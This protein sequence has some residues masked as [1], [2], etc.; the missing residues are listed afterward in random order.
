MT[1]LPDALDGVPLA[2]ASL[3]VATADGDLHLH[4]TEAGPADGTPVLLLHGFPEWWYGWRRVIPA[5]ART[6]YRVI[7]P[8]QRGYAGSDR[9]RHAAAYALPNLVADMVAVI[10]QLGSGRVHL[11][12]HDWG[13]AVAWALATA[14][15]D[16]VRTLT[17]VN[18]PHPRVLRRALGRDLEQTRR[19][20][21][22]GLFQLPW[23]PE[24]LLSHGAAERALR[25]TSA[26]GTFSDDELALYRQHAW[27]TPKHLHGPLGW[28]RAARFGGFPP[29]RVN[30]PT[31]LVWGT[32]DHALGTSLCAPSLERCDDARLVPI[33]GCSHWVPAERP[34]ALLSTLQ[35]HFGDHGGVDPFVYK[36]VPRA[37]WEAAG[38]VWSGSADDLRDGFVH[39]SAADQ[40][41]GT[42]DKHFAGQDDLLCLTVDPSQLPPCGLRWEV[43]RGGRRFP[44]LYGGLPRAAVREVRPLP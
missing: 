24:R 42:R 38:V 27:A 22:M 5:L 4:V 35:Q 26:P 6:G 34:D 9:P 44:H 2:H 31:V 1:S 39:L 41:A 36:I 13:G 14:H 16:R 33:E 37:V 15:P 25:D 30:V 12:G 32:A 18:C 10:D 23:L 11:V 21:Y 40:V 28:Y 8:D 43:S 7:V 29:G 3:K 19:S 20:W 17:V